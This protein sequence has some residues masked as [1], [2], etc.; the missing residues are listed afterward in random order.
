MPGDYWQ[1]FAGLRLLYCYFLCHPG[2]KLLFMGG[3]FAQFIE[4]R[5]DA[6]LDWFLLDFEMHKQYQSYVQT[7]GRLYRQEKSLWQK[8]RG[9]EGFAWVDADNAEQS[10]LVF[11]RLAQ[12]KRDFLLVVLNFQPETY[13][14]FRVGVPSPGKYQEILNTDSK[15]FGG[16]GQVNAGII[17]AEEIPWHWQEYSLKITVPPLAGVIFKPV[18]A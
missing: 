2:K 14:D 10:I 17:K 11:I 12:E 3:E 6:E 18:R 7:A 4:W 15:A 13:R 9:W 16:S 5:Y 8:E 1:K